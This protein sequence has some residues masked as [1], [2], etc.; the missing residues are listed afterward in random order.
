M[1][2][3]QIL[4]LLFL[5]TSICSSIEYNSD[6]QKIINEVNIDSLRIYVEE[7]T[8]EKEV[9]INGEKHKILTRYCRSYGNDL[10][11]DYLANRLES[12][13]LKSESQEFKINNDSS[14]FLEYT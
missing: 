9:L 13:G 5:S 1:K 7:L 14:L 8:G 12:F 4:I 10:A 3:I 6:I 11:A 2:K